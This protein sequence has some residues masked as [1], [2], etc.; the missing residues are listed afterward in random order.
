LL[1]P[2]GLGL[3]SAVAQVMAHLGVQGAFDEDFLEIL[4][5]IFE[6]LLGDRTRNELF[7]HL[8]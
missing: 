2:S 5:D 1:A 7:E 6:L 3:S 8:G 4:E